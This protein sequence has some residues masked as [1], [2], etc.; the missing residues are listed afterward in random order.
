[1]PPK[2]N[3]QTEATVDVLWLSHTGEEH[4]YFT[5]LP[6]CC[7]TQSTFEGNVWLVRDS[8]TQKLLHRVKVALCSSVGRR[9]RYLIR[10]L[11]SQQHMLR[12]SANI[13]AAAAGRG[14]D[15]AA[16]ADAAA[17]GGNAAPAASIGAG[18]SGKRVVTEDE[19]E[20]DLRVPSCYR[21]VVGTAVGV[22]VVAHGH[23]CMQALCAAADVIEHMLQL[24]PPDVVTRLQDNW[25][26]VAVIGR[27]QVT[28]DVLEHSH[29]R[30]SRTDD[31]R[32]WDCEVRGLGGTMVIPTCSVG[33]ENLLRCPKDRYR[34]ESI[35]VHE[36]AHTVMEVCCHA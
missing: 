32:D 19:A 21:Q 1:M 27:E 6:A 10:P 33:E 34:E 22:P 15:G 13:D 31:G 17:D 12:G 16:P 4:S 14:C 24:T 29:L 28:T 35:L 25:C 3:T 11:P 23:V 26:K 2:L 30:G 9:Q 18:S 36:F 8:A 5:L 7:N 20:G